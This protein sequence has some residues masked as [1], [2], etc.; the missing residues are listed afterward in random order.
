MA[1]G[2]CTSSATWHPDESP[3][4]YLRAM[5]ADVDDELRK[6]TGDQGS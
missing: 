4:K 3:G 1:R 6:L 5:T 2:G